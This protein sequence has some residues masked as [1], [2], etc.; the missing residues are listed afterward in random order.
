MWKLE[1]VI[2]V[3][4]LMAKVNWETFFFRRNGVSLCVYVCVFG[5]IFYSCEIAASQLSR[6]HCFRTSRCQSTVGKGLIH[7]EM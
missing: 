5:D 3:D 2:S 1:T 6:G 7:R 4:I